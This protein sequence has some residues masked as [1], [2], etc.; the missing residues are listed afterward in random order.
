MSFNHILGD[1]I[2]I[3]YSCKL[4]CLKLKKMQ[5]PEQIF[6]LTSL[7]G[8]PEENNSHQNDGGDYVGQA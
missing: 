4:C 1:V 5:K 7:R 3:Y 6:I 2:A 8:N